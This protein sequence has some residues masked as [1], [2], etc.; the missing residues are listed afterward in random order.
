MRAASIRRR[1]VNRTKRAFYTKLHVPSRGYSPVRSASSPRASTPASTPAR[2]PARSPV[3]S[4]SRSPVY[5]RTH[6]AL[7][8]SNAPKPKRKLNFGKTPVAYKP[9]SAPPP[10]PPRA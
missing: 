2:T 6:P 5:A 10:T 9:S 4:L 8:R 1:M 7:R 3:R